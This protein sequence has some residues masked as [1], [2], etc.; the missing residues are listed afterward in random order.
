MQCCTW[1]RRTEEPS[2]GEDVR[3][4]GS[5]HDPVAPGPRVQKFRPGALCRSMRVP[6][7]PPVAQRKRTRPQCEV[8]DLDSPDE[9][10]QPA[11]Q[12]RDI[13]R[14]LPQERALCSERP[15]LPPHG[16]AHPRVGVFQWQTFIATSFPFNPSLLQVPTGIGSVSSAPR[17]QDLRTTG[18]TAD[19]AFVQTACGFTNVKGLFQ[20]HELQR[21]LGHCVPIST[22]SERYA[23]ILAHTCCDCFRVHCAFY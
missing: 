20:M 17:H 2:A 12:H 23:P 8:T 7:H 1:H 9:V 10:Y 15:L 5:L 13:G 18:G 22:W 6:P 3:R 16:P 19:Q 11:P 14:C 21:V 4:R